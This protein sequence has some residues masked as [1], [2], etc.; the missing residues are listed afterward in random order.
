MSDNGDDACGIHTRA[1][2]SRITDPEFPAEWIYDANGDPTCTAFEKQDLDLA[3]RIAVILHRSH[4][5]TWA[6]LDTI[7]TALGV[8]LQ[9]VRAALIP[10]WFRSYIKV[11]TRLGLIEIE[12]LSVILTHRGIDRLQEHEAKS[13]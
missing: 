2:W 6:S 13:A 7:A 8:D 10:L 5:G 12:P 4:L 9:A 3:H 1:I 11:S